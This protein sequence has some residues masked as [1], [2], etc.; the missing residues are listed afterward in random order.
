LS[1]PSFPDFIE[2]ILAQQAHNKRYNVAFILKD[3]CGSMLPLMEND[4]L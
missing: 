4:F 1:S 3:Y 2:K